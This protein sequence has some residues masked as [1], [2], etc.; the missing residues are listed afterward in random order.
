MAINSTQRYLDVEKSN[1]FL[2]GLLKQEDKPE[3]KPL[4]ETV[5]VDIDVDI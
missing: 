1:R 2:T 3:I 5:E 4:S